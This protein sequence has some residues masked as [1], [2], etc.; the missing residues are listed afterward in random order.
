MEHVNSSDKDLNRHQQ[1][2]GS[3]VWAGD[4]VDIPSSVIT[5]STPEAAEIVRGLEKF[6]GESIPLEY[7]QICRRRQAGTE[8]TELGLDIRNVNAE[9]FPLPNVGQL[10]QDI[11]VNI[12]DG[13]GF[14]IIRG[15]KPA[16]HSTEDFM[17]IYL[18][19]ASH[20]GS[21]RGVQNRRGEMI[22]EI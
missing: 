21:Q 1:L 20:V 5:L 22:C 10:L 8:S 4:D 17:T 11:A 7:G 14:N 18:G 6:K 16:H 15:L 19:I 13:T 3:L 9:N 2:E 12:H